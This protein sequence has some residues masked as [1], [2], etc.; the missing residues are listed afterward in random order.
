MAN[1][2]T[3]ISELTTEPAEITRLSLNYPIDLYIL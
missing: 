1:L 2:L 3:R